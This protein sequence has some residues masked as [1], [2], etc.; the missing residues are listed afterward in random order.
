[1]KDI[2]TPTR[3]YIEDHILMGAASPFNDGDSLIE[4]RIVD[5]TGLLE[6]ITFIEDEFGLSVDESEMVPENLESLERIEA[7]VRRKLPA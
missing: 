5:S 7:Y 2:K 1:L 3:R 6:L 4:H